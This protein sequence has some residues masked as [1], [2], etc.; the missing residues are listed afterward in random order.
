MKMGRRHLHLLLAPCAAGQLL[1]PSSRMVPR[2]SDPLTGS[3][4]FEMRELLSLSNFPTFMGVAEE[5]DLEE[6]DVLANMNWYVYPQTGIIQ[7]HPLVPLKY[8]Y[9]HQHNAVVGKT[10]GKHHDD[11]AALIARQRSGA[12]VLEIGGGHG[13]LAAKLLFSGAVEKWTMVDPNP[14]SAFSIPN[15]GI[16]RSYIEDVKELPEDVDMIVHSHTLEHMYN[17]GKFFDIIWSLLKPGQLHIF[18]VPNLY[19]LLKHDHPS[20]NFEHTIMLREEHIDWLLEQRGFDVVEKH[21]F[22]E[23][24]S[25]FYV[26]KKKSAKPPPAQP[27]SFYEANLRVFTR[28]YRHIKA[29]AVLFAASLSP[30]KSHNFVY[31][32]HVGTQ[33]LFS[34]GLP[35]ERFAGVLDNNHDKVGRR[36]Y[37][38]NLTVFYPNALAKIKEPRVVLRTGVYD[39]EI[40]AQLRSINPATIFIRRRENYTASPQQDLVHAGRSRARHIHHEHRSQHA[41]HVAR[42]VAE[43]VE[44]EVRAR[45]GERASMQHARSDLATTKHDM[46][47]A[48]RPP[49]GETPPDVAWCIHGQLRGF[50]RRE[51]HESMKSN[52][53][54]AFG[55]AARDIFFHIKVPSNIDNETLAETRAALDS[56]K[57]RGVVIADESKDHDRRR[58]FLST[59][60][61]A[62]CGLPAAWHH[63]VS[64]AYSWLDKRDCY[65]QIL[66][67]EETR[68][69]Q[70]DLVGKARSDVQYCNAW[71]SYGTF[72]W[73]RFAS[74][75]TIATPYRAVRH[76]WAVNKVIEGNSAMM[77]RAHSDVYFG[78]YQQLLSCQKEKDYRVHCD[79]FIGPECYLGTWIANNHVNFDNGI[80]PGSGSVG[81]QS[82]CIWR[83]ETHTKPAVCNCTAG[84]APSM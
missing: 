13:Y 48:R 62:S 17:P 72:D 4:G 15:L 60:P 45:S 31:A 50:N 59:S 54:D 14:I 81:A 32:A 67:A 79:G 84:T 29:D 27:P 2:Q 78:A 38:T 68:G 44:S 71:P 77:L 11:F 18:S 51:V 53:V 66:A 83:S 9:R 80:K 8:L 6:D 41:D 1:V 55:G 63:A 26:C 47:S 28:W 64:I 19:E 70:Y 57:P 52:L 75:D 33:Y 25:L 7:L 56:F 65:Q 23:I 46:L 24:H 49:F 16:I 82:H 74:T 21:H 3:D 30:D 58:E 34:A 39:D 35:R 22:A 36:L 76:R 20:L 43:D 42:M 40:E 5:N 73:E 12:H 69:R 10:W 37:G 61:N